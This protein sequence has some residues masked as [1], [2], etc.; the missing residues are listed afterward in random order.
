VIVIKVLRYFKFIIL[1][2]F[3]LIYGSITFLRNIFFDLGFFKHFII[4]VKSIVVGNLTVGGTGKTPHVI[5]LAK[6][7][8]E[9]EKLAVLSRGYGRKSKG[10]LDV[11]TQSD[12]KLVGDEPLLIKKSI[13]SKANVAVCE[14]RKEGILKLMKDFNSNLIILDDA[15]QHRKVKA[16]MNILLTEMNRPYFNDYVMPLG[17][18]REFS[19]GKKRA[20]M[21]IVTKCNSNVSQSFKN[22][23]IAKSSFSAD[24]VFFSSIKY[25]DFIFFSKVQS[26]VPRFI[27]LVTAIASDLKII[28]HLDE[29][30]SVKTLKFPDH[31]SYT[32]EDI[33]KIHLKFDT[34]PKGE[35][36]ILTTEKD[37][38]KLN[39]F[40]E[41]KDST[42][43]WAYLPIEVEIDREKDFIN[44]IQNYVG[45]V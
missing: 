12:P 31:H 45:A 18:L 4:P 32:I 15:F 42:I 30:F 33:Q 35:T 20:D 9:S 24:N 38:M 14:S 26:F 28:E 25:G 5:Y 29:N 39:T 1:F 17:R 36:L 37:F 7:L 10:Y 40:S 21:L 41:V 16:G 8:S 34:L 3:S 2:P 27:F 19:F 6:L 13:S 22:Q 43:P 11:L 23:F 44:K